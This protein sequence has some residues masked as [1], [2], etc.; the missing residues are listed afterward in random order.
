M[1]MNLGQRDEPRATDYKSGNEF[2]F[3]YAAQ[4]HLSRNFALGIEEYYYRQ[5]SDDTEKGMTVNTMPPSGRFQS[6]DP[7]NA[8]RVAMGRPSPW[9]PWSA[10][11]RLLTCF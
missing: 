7:L 5:I 1:L 10:I 11:T 9:V 4:R 3:T 2:Y 6:Q 8:A